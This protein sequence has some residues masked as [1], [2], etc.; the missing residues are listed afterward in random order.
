MTDTYQTTTGIAGGMRN[1][2]IIIKGIPN[3]LG[4]NAAAKALSLS[5]S[6]HIVIEYLA[7]ESDNFLMNYQSIQ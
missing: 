7:L 3:R 2:T 5:L 1:N 4:V 6:P